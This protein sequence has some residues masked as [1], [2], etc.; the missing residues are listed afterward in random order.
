MF[1]KA[2]EY[3]I[4]ATVFI[5]K[6]ETE[7]KNPSLK[8]IAK[9]IDSPEAFTSKILQK[10][11]HHKVIRSIRGPKG[12]FA[13]IP[14]KKNTLTLAEV[15]DAIDGDQVYSG[16]ALG[17]QTCS[18]EKPC[19]LHHKFKGVRNRLSN[20]LNKTTIKKLAEDLNK[21]DYYLKI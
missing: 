18:E 6:S 14:E 8:E 11:V 7:G 21:G 13:M 4:R 20:L 1:S 2:C 9:D 5:A 19:P 10:L 3:G 16:C 15:V 12:G 17:L